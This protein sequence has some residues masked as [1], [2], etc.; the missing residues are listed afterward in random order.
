MS[1]EES[2]PPFPPMSPAEPAEL[3]EELED[4]QNAA[5]QQGT[6][7]LEDGNLDLALEKFTEAILV[8]CASA[9]LYSRRADLLLKLG[10]PRAAIQDC[11]AALEVKPDSAKAFKIR[12]RA[13]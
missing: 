10:R 6:D 13:Y 5:K 9:L 11:T 2:E 4:K 8:G 1:V 3:T 7:A 12:A